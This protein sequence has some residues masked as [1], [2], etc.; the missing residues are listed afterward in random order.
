MLREW[1][2]PEGIHVDVTTEG[3]CQVL[4]IEIKRGLARYGVSK[5]P[6]CP[7]RSGVIL[8][9]P[10]KNEFFLRDVAK[11]TVNGIEKLVPYSATARYEID[12]SRRAIWMSVRFQS[13]GA[14]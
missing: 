3:A 6:P 12:A 8:H 13:D 1:I 5:P 2:R 7:S 14:L 11:I 10:D 9:Q 4:E